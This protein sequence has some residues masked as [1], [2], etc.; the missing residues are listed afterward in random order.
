MNIPGQ[1]EDWIRKGNK[2][3]RPKYLNE[4]VCIS[5]L[6]ALRVQTNNHSPNV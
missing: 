4:H 5:Y 3:E 6:P 1:F 2:T